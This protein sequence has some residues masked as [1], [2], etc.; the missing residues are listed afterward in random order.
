[1]YGMFKGHQH[2]RHGHKKRHSLKNN[3]GHHHGRHHG[4]HARADGHDHFGKYGHWGRFNTE[5]GAGYDQPD[6][7]K[8]PAVRLIEETK[9]ATD[10]LVCPFCENQCLLDDPGCRKGEAYVRSLKQ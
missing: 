10:S 8:P 7:E 1:M 2:G 5:V 4:R 3:H 9:L 6:F